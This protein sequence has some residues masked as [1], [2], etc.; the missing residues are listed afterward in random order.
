MGI[1]DRATETLYRLKIIFS[2]KEYNY[3]SRKRDRIR[4]TAEDRLPADRL[5]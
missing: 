3:V 1:Y 4:M 5:T 2:A